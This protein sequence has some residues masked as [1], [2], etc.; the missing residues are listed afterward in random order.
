MKSR[1]LLWVLC[2]SMQCNLGSAMAQSMAPT[3]PAA[4]RPTRPT[5]PTRD[6]ATSGYVTAKE[7]PDATVAPKDTDG[8]FIL[9]STH[10][11]ASEMTPQEGV[12]QG[13]VS[14]FTMLSS[15]SKI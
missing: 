5:P 9:G 11:P 6:P 7:L 3:Q 15:D 10:N 4:A 2:L 13:T 8:N 14:T 1:W 12:P